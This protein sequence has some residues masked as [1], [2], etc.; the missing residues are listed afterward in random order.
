M[1]EV[2][3]ADIDLCVP[4]PTM[5]VPIILEIRHASDLSV[6]TDDGLLAISS[7]ASYA[8]EQIISQYQPPFENFKCN[9]ANLQLTSC[10]TLGKKQLQNRILL[11]CMYM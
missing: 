8:E 9:L 1:S 2:N 3:F 4:K 10:E 5:E 6:C 11:E 7:L